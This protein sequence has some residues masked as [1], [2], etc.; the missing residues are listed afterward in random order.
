VSVFDHDTCAIRLAA[1]HEF[2]GQSGPPEFA[3]HLAFAWLSPVAIA[4]WLSSRRT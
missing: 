2:T 1:H 4:Y 3:M